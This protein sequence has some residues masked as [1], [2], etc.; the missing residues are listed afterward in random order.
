MAHRFKISK[1]T[2]ML[3]DDCKSALEDER[4]KHREGWDN[5]SE[6]WQEGDRAETADEW[7]DKF[8]D[9]ITELEMI[10]DAPEYED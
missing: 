9:V 1:A 2:R 7:V 6:R 8:D 10:Q 4:D 5:A 3:I